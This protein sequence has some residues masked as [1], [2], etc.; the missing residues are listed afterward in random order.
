MG[1]ITTVIIAVLLVLVMGLA[2]SLFLMMSRFRE[3]NEELKAKL[4]AIEAR[5][6]FPEKKEKAKAAAPESRPQQPAK[7]KA[8]NPSSAELV[9][10]RKETARQR[11]E[12][13]RIKV[14]LRDKTREVADASEKAEKD[15]Y[16][17][18]E[19]NRRLLETVRELDAQSAAR[20]Q[21]GETVRELNRTLE[22]AHQDNAALQRRIEELEKAQS[23]RNE[24]TEDLRR[25]L[26]DANGELRRW[27]ETAT[28]ANGKP[29]TPA[30]F[31]KWR[32]RALVGRDMYQMMKQLRELSDH[33]LATYQDA[34]LEISRFC[35]D[36]LGEPYPAVQPGEVVADRHLGAALAA[37]HERFPVENLAVSAAK[38]EAVVVENPA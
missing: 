11:D 12:L 13:A 24:A 7:V 19:E 29:L 4:V 31:A 6:A 22:R 28:L 3:R 21:A 36:T 33:K 35:L 23:G 14:E 5:K 10:L 20:Q 34:V 25:Q 26:H 38:T 9:E 30:L 37:L 8:A 18:R 17:L 2:I 1:S 27:R 15:L 16:Q 32:Q